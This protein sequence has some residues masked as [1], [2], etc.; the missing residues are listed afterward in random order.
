MHGNNQIKLL[1]APNIKVNIK[2]ILIGIHHFM[3][4]LKKS[5]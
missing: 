3:V 2:L 5:N 1:Y 4:S